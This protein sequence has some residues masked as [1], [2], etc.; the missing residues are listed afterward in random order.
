MSRKTG[1]LRSA[2]NYSRRESCG[3]GNCRKKVSEKQAAGRRD[4]ADSAPCRSEITMLTSMDFTRL[5][6]DRP[7]GSETRL[8]PTKVCSRQQDSTRRAQTHRHQEDSP[9]RLRADRD[10]P[11]VRVRLLGHAGV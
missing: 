5:A 10:W 3:K 1:E 8:E 11:G 6:T 4:L 2:G 9:D 7:A